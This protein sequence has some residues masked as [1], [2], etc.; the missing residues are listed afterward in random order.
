MKFYEELDDNTLFSY[1][2]EGDS[3]A[4]ECLYKRYWKQLFNT[5]YKRIPWQEKCEEIIQ[6]VYLDIWQKRGKIY[7][8]NNFK[9]YLFSA[10]RYKVFNQ[11]RSDLVRDEYINQISKESN[12][13]YNPGHDIVFYNELNEAINRNI[14]KLP[15]KCRK[16]FEL[17]F[18]EQMS[19]KEISQ[20][21]DISE[22][23]VVKHKLKAFKYLKEGLKEYVS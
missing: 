2:K 14:E 22:N 19:V 17:S 9:S 10:L 16:V 13:S 5:A 1:V 20:N 8:V 3:N 7:L 11:I 6:E 21:M 18:K 12:I 15:D 23:T 4:F